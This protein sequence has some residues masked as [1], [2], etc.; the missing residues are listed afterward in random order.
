M[1]RKPTYED[2]VRLARKELGVIK[3][4]IVSQWLFYWDEVLENWQCVLNP[5]V[6]GCLRSVARELGYD[7]RKVKGHML[8]YESECPQE[9]IFGYL[10][11]FPAKGEWQE[12]KE[13]AE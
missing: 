3:K 4:D 2:Y 13:D 11:Q 6:L 8:R 10:K 1:K 5:N 9:D 12:A 7:P